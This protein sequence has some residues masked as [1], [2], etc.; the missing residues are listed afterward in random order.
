MANLPNNN[1][2]FCMI[3]LGYRT[4]LLY[5]TRNSYKWNLSILR[6]VHFDLF[7]LDYCIVFGEV[8]CK[9]TCMFIEIFINVRKTKRIERHTNI[10]RKVSKV[11]TIDLGVLDRLIFFSQLHTKT[12]DPVLIQAKH[13]QL[14]FHGSFKP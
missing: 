2:T 6:Q 14:K 5:C 8:L 11:N 7:T 10:I 4:L 9:N 1:N 3:L 13:M 12:V